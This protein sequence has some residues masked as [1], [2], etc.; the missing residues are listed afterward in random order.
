MASS[1]RGLESIRIDTQ[2]NRGSVYDVISAVTGCAQGDLN[3]NRSRLVEQYPA[4]RPGGT[5]VQRIRINGVGQ[6]TPVALASTLLELAW[7]LSG[8]VAR[9]F[10]RAGALKVCRILGGDLT[11]IDEIE[12]HHKRVAG[13]PQE[14]FLLGTDAIAPNQAAVPRKEPTAMMQYNLEIKQLEERKA[15]RE[16]RRAERE[17]AGP[18]KRM[19]FAVEWRSVLQGVGAYTVTDEVRLCEA[20]KMLPV[21]VACFLS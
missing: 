4:F 3:R 2:T 5:A 19:Q 20:Q 12:R 18:A 10:R 17:A 9:E 7:V 15:E 8:K 1:L 21:S 11:L 6:Q 14:Q 16:D 13:T